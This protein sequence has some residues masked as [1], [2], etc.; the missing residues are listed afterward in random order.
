ML[1]PIDEIVANFEFLDD[2]DDRYRYLMELGRMV[3]PL[4]E[5]ARSEANKVHGCASQVWLD[6]RL[7]PGPGGG[8][9]RLTGDSDS[10]IVRGLLAFLVAVYSGKTASEALA[11]DGLDRMRS[12][13]LDQFISSRRTGGARAMVE[14]IRRDAESA[15]AA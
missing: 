3:E 7:E 5:A 6:T 9:L 11:T 4:P 8:V 1:P 2:W 10:D 13:G 12:L 14:R 15:L